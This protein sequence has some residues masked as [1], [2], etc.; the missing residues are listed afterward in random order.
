LVDGDAALVLENFVQGD[1]GI[2]DDELV[3]VFDE[4]VEFVDDIGFCCES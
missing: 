1:N 3:G 2:G 4:L